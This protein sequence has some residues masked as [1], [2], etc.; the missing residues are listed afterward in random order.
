MRITAI[1]I[2]TSKQMAEMKLENIDYFQWIELAE[3][4]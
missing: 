4:K 2:T 3:W 1:G